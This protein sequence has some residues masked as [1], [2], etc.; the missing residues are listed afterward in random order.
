MSFSRWCLASFLG[1][2]MVLLAGCK[3]DD[4]GPGKGGPG[5]GGPPGG[6]P[7]GFPPMPPMPLEEKEPHAAGK[8][9]Y[10]ANGCMK[11]HSMGGGQAGF[12]MPPMPPMGGPPN[13][14]PMPNQ[15]PDLAKVASKPERNVDW[16]IAFL[17]N[18]SKD[19]PEARMPPFEGKIQA[20]DLRALAEFLASLK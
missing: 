11:C 14:P 12:P 15:G 16:F 8:R 19:N 5:P 10:N 6:P 2:S 13:M 4:P 1:L 3:E 17:N 9:V 7:G 20:D 18:P